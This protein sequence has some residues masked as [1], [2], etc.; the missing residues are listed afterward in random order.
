[1]YIL[2]FFKKRK[3]NR[4]REK[5]AMAQMAQISPKFEKVFTRKTEPQQNPNDFKKLSNLGEIWAI[6][7]RG[8][9]GEFH[10]GGYIVLRTKGRSPTRLNFGLLLP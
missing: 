7:A 2:F 8:I 3:T 10:I 4:K 9:L 5:K 6:W 1:L